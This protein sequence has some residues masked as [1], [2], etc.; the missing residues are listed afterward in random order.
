MG[1]KPEPDPYDEQQFRQDHKP[2]KE[3]AEKYHQQKVEEGRK[4]KEKREAKEEQER[5]EPVINK[6]IDED[7]E[8]AN[9]DSGP[10]RTPEEES[11]RNDWAARYFSRNEHFGFGHNSG[12]N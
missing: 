3:A 2:S 1:K 10:S 5:Q 11:A 6:M 9:S 12:R 8:D 7:R 4:K